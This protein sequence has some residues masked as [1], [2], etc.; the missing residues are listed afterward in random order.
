VF[1]CLCDQ[2]VLSTEEVLSATG[3]AEE[4]LRTGWSFGAA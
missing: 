1:M 4:G 3:R 2:Y